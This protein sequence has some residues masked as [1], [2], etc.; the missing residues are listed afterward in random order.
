MSYLIHHTSY[1]NMPFGEDIE[2]NETNL[3]YTVNSLIK[4]IDTISIKVRQ[5][6]EIVFSTCSYESVNDEL[7]NENTIDKLNILK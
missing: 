1:L 3:S 2:V 7:I 5:N 6:D 4:N